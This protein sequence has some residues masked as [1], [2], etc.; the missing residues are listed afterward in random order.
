MH[1]EGAEKM[2]LSSDMLIEGA[3]KTVATAGVREKLATGDLP[4]IRVRSVTITAEADNTGSVYVGGGNVSSTVYGKELKA[5]ESVD[6][7]VEQRAWERG[8]SVNLSRIWLD[9]SVNGDG[10][11][12]LTERV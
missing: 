9:V 6:I 12:Y 3:V 8:E 2:S 4:N 11:S 7:S 5:G 10:V 1:A